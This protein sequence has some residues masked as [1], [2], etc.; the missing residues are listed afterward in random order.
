M[1]RCEEFRTSVLKH[2]YFP[3]PGGQFITGN[4]VSGMVT[5]PVSMYQTVVTSIAQLQESQQ[6]GVQIAMAPNSES[7]SQSG[8]V[9][10]AT[11]AVEVMTV[12]QT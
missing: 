5:I 7:M 9:P 6:Q 10:D 3:P 1:S 12:E 11:H 8:D 2:L 4:T